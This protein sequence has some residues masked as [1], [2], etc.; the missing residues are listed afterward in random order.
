MEAKRVKFEG[1]VDFRGVLLVLG[2]IF[3]GFVVIS[4]LDQVVQG[5][6]IPT[7]LNTTYNDV[8]DKSGLLLKIGVFGL[9]MFVVWQLF[10]KQ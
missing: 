9:I 4:V 2:M 3:A 8:L 7:S 1:Q 5:I 6:G 10:L